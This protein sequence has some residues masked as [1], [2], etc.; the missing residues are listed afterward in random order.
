M[1][2]TRQAITRTL[3]TILLGATIPSV[4][5]VVNQIDMRK[6]S[7]FANTPACVQDCLYCCHD[8][9]WQSACYTNECFCLA[10]Q[11][12]NRL[13]YV[14][15]CVSIQ[16]D[17]NNT[18]VIAAT[19]IVNSYCL[20][21]LWTSIYPVLTDAAATSPTGPI[22]VTVPTG[23]VWEPPSSVTSS[24]I[25]PATTSQ[26]S[27]S[28]QSFTM[29]DTSAVVT[30]SSSTSAG[31]RISE[32]AF[33]FITFN[34]RPLLTGTC[35]TP[36]FT[37]VPDSVISPYLWYPFVGC[38]EERLNCCPFPESPQGVPYV[39]LP[40]SSQALGR[41]PQDYSAVGSNCCPT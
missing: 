8:V 24:R 9:A 10:S 25:T 11:L 28:T 29:A 33:N 30:A 15:Y 7:G 37:P 38:L 26:E 22:E 31:A 3:R 21:S 41:C 12:S 36:T 34:G 16:C 13:D 32:T 6:V 5:A 17:G 2:A 14:E 20:S 1:H 40:S 39:D 27:S 19:S 4:L 23:F 35:G 18:D